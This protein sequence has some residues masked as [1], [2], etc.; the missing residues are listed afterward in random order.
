M[1][2]QNI[3]F[4]NKFGFCKYLEKCRKFHENKKCE[5]FDCEIRDCPYRHPKVCKFFRDF[6]FCKFSEWC[7]FS[8]NVDKT[9]NTENEEVKKLEVRLKSVEAELKKKSEKVVKL[10]AEIMDINRKISEK[11]QNV[12]KINKK[13]NFLKEKVTLLFDL[14]AKFDTLEKKFENLNDISTNAIEKV[15]DSQTQEKAG[16]AENTEVETVT[17]VEEQT[18]E[19]VLKCDSCDQITSTNLRNL[20]EIIFSKT[21]KKSQKYFPDCIFK[22]NGW[23]IKKKTIP[24]LPFICR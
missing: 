6:G 13:F 19:I 1:A 2:A 18:D 10:E 12:S 14:E 22:T 9:T 17:D 4:Y 20:P 23:N 24:R 15:A 11:D 3:C 8:H 7:K 5:K 16:S 21:W